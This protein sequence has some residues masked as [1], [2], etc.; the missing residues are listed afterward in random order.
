MLEVTLTTQNFEEEVLKSEKPVL[1]DFWATWCSPCKMIAPI[2][3]EFAEEYKEKVKVGKV[4]VDEQ[5]D[6][7]MKYQISS[8]PTLILF[9]NGHIINN[10]VG[11][12]SKQ[13]L[14]KMINV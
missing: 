11:F 4:N 8:I 10:L 13:E 3:A 14:E 5:R 9:K 6:L 12:H 1:V 7:A 2:L